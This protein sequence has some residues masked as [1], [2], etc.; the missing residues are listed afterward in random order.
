MLLKDSISKTKKLFNKTIQSIMSLLSGGY[1][2]LPKTQPLTHLFSCGTNDFQIHELEQLYRD[3]LTDDYS[4]SLM[5][6]AKQNSAKSKQEES[7]TR[8]PEGEKRSESCSKGREEMGDLLARKMKE[9]EMMDMGN[10]DHVLDIE[11][12]LHYYS[13]LKCPAYLDI[14]DKFFMEMYSELFL[15]HGSTR[16]GN[17]RR[18][19][20]H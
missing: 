14:V 17:S 16:I 3:L 9:L 20:D 11:E 6:F 1:Q 4:G 2:K 5:K 10:V 13:R 19:L 7:K 18:S 15:P 8:V 12:V